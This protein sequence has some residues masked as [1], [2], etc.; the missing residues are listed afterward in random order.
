[1]HKKRK[2]K[3]KDIHCERK[4]I[5]EYLSAPKILYNCKFNFFNFAMFKFNHYLI[6]LGIK[7]FSL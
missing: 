1:M 7:I 3:M 4:K 6:R 2:W 5:P